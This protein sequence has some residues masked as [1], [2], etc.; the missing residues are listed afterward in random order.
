MTFT[1]AIRATK[2]PDREYRISKIS[3]PEVSCKLGYS[4]GAEYDEAYNED[5]D[6]LQGAHTE[7]FHRRVLS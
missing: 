1:A 6:Y 2:I 5:N 7:K 4:L 3:F